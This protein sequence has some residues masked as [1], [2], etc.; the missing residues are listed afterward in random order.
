[1]GRPKNKTKRKAFSTTIKIE[2]LDQL[3]K[4]SEEE[5]IPVNRLI[6]V[7]LEKYLEEIKIDI[8]NK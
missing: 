3:K 1:M 6:E 5:G 4:I 8:K 7:S 2:L